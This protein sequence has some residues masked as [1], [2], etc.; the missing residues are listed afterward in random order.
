MLARARQLAL[1]RLA[2]IGRAGERDLVHTGVLD[3]R[4][5]GA[6]VAGD[7]VDDTGRELSLPEDVA[8]VERGQRGRLRRLEDDRVACCERGRD[9]PRQHEQR[10]V[11]GDDLA[12]DADRPRL[13]V[14]ERVLELVRPACVIEEVRRRERQV[15]VAGLADRLAAVQ[16]F[17]DG[18]LA[19]ALLQDARDPE[20]VLRALRRRDR[21]P[22][23]LESVAGRLDGEVDLL[24]SRLPDLGERLLARRVDRRRRSPSARATRLRRSARSDLGAER[25]RAP[26]EPARS[27][28]RPEPARDPACA[29]GRSQALGGAGRPVPTTHPPP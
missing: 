3:D 5:P 27:P 12:G 19:R 1:D 11:P 16:R 17:E 8:E 14:R 25:G 6:A 4:G 21:R 2:D 18:E 29:R 28:R 9:L 26:R 24:G 20:E 15:D 13:A 23:V 10:E 22:A 7:D